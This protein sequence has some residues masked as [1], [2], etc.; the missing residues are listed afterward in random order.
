MSQRNRSPRHQN[1]SSQRNRNDIP[2][3]QIGMGCFSLIIILV[4]IS[5]W[6]IILMFLAIL[7]LGY[8]A[9]RFRREIAYFLG[10]FFQWLWRCGVLFVQWCREKH[11]RQ[12][13]E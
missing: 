4:V 7:F 6:Q 8:L 10:R 3:S 11:N 12:L 13:D 5:Y 1:K 9:I 2:S